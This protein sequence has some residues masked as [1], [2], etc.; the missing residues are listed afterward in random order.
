MKGDLGITLK[1]TNLRSS[2]TE[3]YDTNWS[4]MKTYV[5]KMT[6][7]EEITNVEEGELLKPISSEKGKTGSL[8]TSNML[9]NDSEP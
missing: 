9:F 8:G 1:E 3:R 4:R 2:H 5:R 7:M 6:V